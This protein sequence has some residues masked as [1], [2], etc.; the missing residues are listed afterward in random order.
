M[1]EFI[2]QILRALVEGHQARDG[3]KERNR[4]LSEY[5]IARRAGYTNFSYVEFSTTRE[6]HQVRAALDELERDGWV[7]QFQRAGRYET[8]VP[9]ELG[10][11]R[12]STLRLV[13]EHASERAAGRGAAVPLADPPPA[14]Q[15]APL[16][17]TP[18]LPHA[19]APEAALARLVQQMDEML[20][21]LRSINSKLEGDR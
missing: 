18:P 17:V 7:T 11:R 3:L 5:E 12:L 1:D 10:V 9:T 2:V 8:F 21:L 14:N 20:G 19:L 13:Q 4:A 16:V 6:R 15:D